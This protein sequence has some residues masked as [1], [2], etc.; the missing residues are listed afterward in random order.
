MDHIMVCIFHRTRLRSISTYNLHCTETGSKETNIPRKQ[1]R[2]FN[3]SRLLKITIFIYIPS[4]LWIR[5]LSW[6]IFDDTN[7]PITLLEIR[8]TDVELWL[9]HNSETWSH[10][11]LQNTNRCAFHMLYLFFLLYSYP[12][13]VWIPTETTVHAYKNMATTKDMAKYIATTNSH[14][15]ACVWCSTDSKAD[16]RS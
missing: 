15:R 10:K 7:S 12:V 6:G 13:H 9:T 11:T 2:G 4:Y 16:I 8:Q 14:N 1:V 5:L 3:H